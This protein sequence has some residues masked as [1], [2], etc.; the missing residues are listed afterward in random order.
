MT[1]GDNTIELVEGVYEYTI[2]VENDIESID[3]KATAENIGSVVSMDI[4]EKLSVGSNVIK[5]TVVA[6]NGETKDYF[7]T[8]VRKEAEQEQVN[9]VPTNNTVN[10]NT[11]NEDKNDTPKPS[12]NSSKDNEPSEN[13]TNNTSKYIIIVLI[14]LVIIGLIYLIFKEDNEEK[15]QVNAPKND[16][17][18]SK[19]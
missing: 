1:V 15:Q 18:K 2:E 8:V 12:D 11:P 13:K 3:V 19:K 7:I 16:K 5:I 4:P 6:E 9:I 10:D 14:I 17:P